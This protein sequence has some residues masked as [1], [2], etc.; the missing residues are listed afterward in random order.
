MKYDQDDVP[1]VEHAEGIY[2]IDTLGSIQETDEIE[3]KR[4]TTW[5]S[6]CAIPSA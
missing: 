1:C 4:S 5:W 2:D 3:N 6:T